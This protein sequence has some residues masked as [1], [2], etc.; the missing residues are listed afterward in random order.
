MFIDSFN[1]NMY[2][3]SFSVTYLKTKINYRYITLLHISIT[4]VYN[5]KYY[6]SSLVKFGCHIF[7]CMF[8]V[9]IL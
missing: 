2:G 8:I 9:W 3:I 4:Y 1:I 6:F 5:L 7:L